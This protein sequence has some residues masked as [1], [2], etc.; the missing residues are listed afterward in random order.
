MYHDPLEESARVNFS[1]QSPEKGLECARRFVYHSAPSFGNALQYAGYRD[2]DNV[3]YILC[4]ADKTLNPEFQHS[5]IDNIN[6]AREEAGKPSARVYQMN[7]GHCPNASKPVEL[8][9]ELVEAI[10]AFD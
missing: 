6:A 2:L 4:T 9:R 5:Q 7:S 1:D 8:A 10:R 3:A